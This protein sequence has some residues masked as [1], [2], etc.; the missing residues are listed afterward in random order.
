M[1]STPGSGASM[2][3][4][5]EGREVPAP[6]PQPVRQTGLQQAWPRGGRAH[7]QVT[8]TLL[9]ASPRLSTLPL[10]LLTLQFWPAGGLSTVT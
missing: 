3:Q 9:T 5:A 1:S 2:R 8:T 10:P 4:F 6:T 7:P